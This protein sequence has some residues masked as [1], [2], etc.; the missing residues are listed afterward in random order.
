MVTPPRPA[1]APGGDWTTLTTTTF[2]CHRAEA[3]RGGTRAGNEQ[4]NRTKREEREEREQLEWISGGEHPRARD[5]PSQLLASR[6]QWCR[7]D[8]TGS[9]RRCHGAGQA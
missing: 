5:N 3:V 8:A 9:L 1:V 6:D 2:G 4:R 7:R